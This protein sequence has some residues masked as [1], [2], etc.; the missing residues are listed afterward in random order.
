[1]ARSFQWVIGRISEG[2]EFAGSPEYLS[3]SGWIWN[4]ALARKWP[5]DDAEEVDAECKRLHE[6][7]GRWCT[8]VVSLDMIPLDLDRSTEKWKPNTWS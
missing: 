5:E 7:L 3:A 6:D 2:G 1:M 4:A 8:R